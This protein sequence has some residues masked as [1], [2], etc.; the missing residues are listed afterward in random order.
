MCNSSAVHL[1]RD[2][3][4]QVREMPGWAQQQKNQRLHEAA[5]GGNLR[6]VQRLVASGADI[7][8]KDDE[9][10]SPLCLAIMNNHLPVVI[11]LL[12]DTGSTTHGGEYLG[13]LD[14]LDMSAS[15]MQEYED[16]I[17][18]YTWEHWR[19]GVSFSLDPKCR[20]A[21]LTKSQI[22]DNYSV[23]RW[24][25]SPPD[26]QKLFRALQQSLLMNTHPE[27]TLSKP[28][29]TRESVLETMDLLWK[30]ERAHSCPQLP[31]WRA[32][33]REALRQTLAVDTTLPLMLQHVVVDYVYEADVV[34]VES[35][36][37]EARAVIAE[38]TFAVAWSTG[39]ALSAPIPTDQRPDNVKEMDT[40]NDKNTNK[41]KNNT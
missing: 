18:D 35:I 22:A 6:E 37:A 26:V 40:G 27:P 9:G 23:L 17:A 11:Y 31:S 2:L 29:Q 34:E 24:F 5:E 10:I 8:A 32:N 3:R 15:E 16:E 39:A 14:G 36:L 12:T 1:D 13:D 4:V 33:R 30:T 21:L 41:G 7:T 38:A 25:G 19:Y 20:A 28:A